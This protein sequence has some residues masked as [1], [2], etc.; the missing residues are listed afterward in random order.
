MSRTPVLSEREAMTE[1]LADLTANLVELQGSLARLLH[2]DLDE[3]AA[4]LIEAVQDA[5]RR[6]EARTREVAIRVRHRA[7]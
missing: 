5:A 6:S 4:Q 2:E 7:W 3:G 1:L